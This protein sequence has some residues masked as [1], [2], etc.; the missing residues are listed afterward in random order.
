MKLVILDP[1][2]TGFGGHNFNYLEGMAREARARGIATRVFAHRACDPAV[3]R[4]LDATPHF[5]TLGRAFV[6]DVEGPES[7]R[8]AWT[9]VV[10]NAMFRRDLEP[11]ARELGPDTVVFVP[12]TSS[13]Q[14][15]ALAE[16]LALLAPPSLPQL[17]CLLRYDI[18][19]YPGEGELLRWPA[20]VLATLK[21]PAAFCCETDENVVAYEAALKVPLKTMPQPFVLRETKSAGE[22]EHGQVVVGYFG[23]ARYMKGSHLLPGLCELAGKGDRGYCLRIQTYDGGTEGQVAGQIAAIKQAAAS[24][25]DAVQ[26]IEG[27]QK[28]E[29]YHQL[30]HDCDVVLLPYRAVAYRRSTSAIFC[31]GVSAGKVMVMPAETSMSAMLRQLGGD[32]VTFDEWS[33]HGVQTALER[34]V[35]EIGRRRREAQALA[36]LW[37]EAHG[38]KAIVDFLVSRARTAVPR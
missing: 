28:L 35:R 26:L 17:V 27:S 20:Q 22:R 1:D 23:D 7:V 4:E 8:V 12:S 3:L 25:P 9:H 31:E 5:A 6:T 21:R 11:L 16:W 15:T 38:P 10:L 24:Y 32:P 29:R 19:S 14:A 13:R 37:N 2:L 30:L 18:D 36:Q 34:A 33:V